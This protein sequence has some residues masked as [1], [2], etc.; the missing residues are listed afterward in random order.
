MTLFTKRYPDVASTAAAHAHYRWLAAVTPADIELP[1]LVH[2]RAQQLVFQLIEGVTPTARQLPDLAAA[3]GR[4]HRAAAGG[5]TGAR[6]DRPHD[7]GG[8]TIADFVTS[9]REALHAAGRIQGVAPAR[10]E[11]V[12]RYAAGLP[13]TIYKD[14]NLRN[15]LV[16]DRGVAVVDFDDLTLAPYGYDLAKLIISTAMTHGP[17]QT[18]HILTALKRYNAHTAP[19]SCTFDDLACWAELTWLLNAPYI[20]RNGYSQPWPKLRPWADPL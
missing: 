5:L 19:D 20:G 16:T 3:L 2:V 17:I 1:S 12:L 7:A 11:T 15:F 6:L 8:L 10:L 18:A 4:L 14:S 9:R 13:P